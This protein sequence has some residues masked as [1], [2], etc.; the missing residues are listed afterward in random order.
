MT[1]SELRKLLT[2][3]FRI[4]DILLSP[5]TLLASL[6]LLFIRKMRVANMPVSKSIFK[7]I[8]VFPILNHYYEP[9]FDDTLLKLPLDGERVLPGIRWN[10]RE[11]LAL[12]EEFHYQE[13]LSAIP[14]DRP[15]AF[16][17]PDADLRFFYGNP[18]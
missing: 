7:K 1:K 16:D 10:D 8:G 14:F 17:A 11:Q 5:F 4:L 2:P 18:S 12:L 3:L 13:E 6:L 9:L 15:D